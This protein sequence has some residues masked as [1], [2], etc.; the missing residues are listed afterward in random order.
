MEKT[1][2]LKIVEKLLHSE[3]DLDF[4]L[5]LP[6]GHLETL[7]VCIRD[8]INQLNNKEWNNDHE[9]SV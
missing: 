1:E 7:V 3:T 8:R 5:D 6:V 9:K 4:L 2:L